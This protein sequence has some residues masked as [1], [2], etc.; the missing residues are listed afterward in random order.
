MTG[1]QRAQKVYNLINIDNLEVS[2]K[3][4]LGWLLGIAGVMSTLITTFH[5]NTSAKQDKLTGI[6][7]SAKIVIDSNA[8]PKFA[9]RADMDTVKREFREAVKF[10]KEDK[11]LLNKLMATV[12]D[13]H[14][15]DSSDIDF[16]GKMEAIHYKYMEQRVTLVETQLHH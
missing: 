4:L 7:D 11:E 13:N 14:R 2:N 5:C 10:F 16:V 3:Q 1:K 15:Q 6:V 9:M 12:N 8:R